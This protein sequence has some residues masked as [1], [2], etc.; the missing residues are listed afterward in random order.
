MFRTETKVTRAEQKIKFVEF[1]LKKFYKWDAP[2]ELQ[3]LKGHCIS[4]LHER[5]IFLRDHSIIPIE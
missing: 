4:V 1:R 3:K 2:K 5:I